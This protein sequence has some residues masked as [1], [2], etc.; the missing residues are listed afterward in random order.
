LIPY[1]DSKEADVRKFAI[2]VVGLIKSRE[3]L[4]FLLPALHDDNPNVASAA[5]EALGNIGAESAVPHLLELY[6]RYEFLQAPIIEALG[7]IGGKE[8]GEFLLTQLS[9]PD[10]FVQCIVIEALGNIGEARANDLMVEAVPHADTELRNTLLMSISQI[11]ERH[12]LPLPPNLES[13]FLRILEQDRAE[14]AGDALAIGDRE[15]R[16]CALKALRHFN[17]DASFEMMINQLGDDE[18]VNRIVLDALAQHPVEVCGYV[19]RALEGRPESRQQL[20]VE[21]VGLLVPYC[22]DRAV[23]SVASGTDSPLAER[24]VAAISKLWDNADADVRRAILDASVKCNAV[25]AMDLVKQALQDADASVREEAMQLYEE[26]VSH[27]K[28]G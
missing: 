16:L 25:Q 24:A 11:A 21:L 10:P 13:Y 3:A 23:E 9:H 17:S 15:R 27:L 28:T 5:V 12:Q 2:D 4:P 22:G 8:A 18:E 26:S 1:I 19:I 6:Q 20:L 7:K 14:S